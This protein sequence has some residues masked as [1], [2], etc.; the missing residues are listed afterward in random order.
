MVRISSV[1]KVRTSATVLK[2][3]KKATQ[4]DHCQLTFDSFVLRFCS[5]LAQHCLRSWCVEKG[6]GGKLSPR[7]LE[8]DSLLKACCR[9][10]FFEVKNRLFRSTFSCCPVQILLHTIGIDTIVLG[11]KERIKTFSDKNDFTV[12]VKRV[13]PRQGTKRRHESKLQPGSRI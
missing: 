9:F 3:S 6:A 1:K 4:M 8:A 11:R 12:P 5:D 2:N 13:A 7:T 10:Y